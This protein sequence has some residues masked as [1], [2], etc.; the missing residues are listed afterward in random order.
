[1]ANQEGKEPLNSSPKPNFKTTFSPTTGLTITLTPKAQLQSLLNAGFFDKSTSLI[2]AQSDDHQYSIR[3]F[4][5][6]WECFNLAN[7]AAYQIISDSK[8]QE[9]A[10][11]EDSEDSD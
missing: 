1:M 11:D 5:T 2:V 10:E 4:G 6:N 9:L 3:I 8:A 7:Y